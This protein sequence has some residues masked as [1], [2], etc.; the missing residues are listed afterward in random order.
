MSYIK[1]T[2]VLLFCV[3]IFIYVDTPFCRKTSCYIVAVA[4]FR[5]GS[6]LSSALDIHFNGLGCSKFGY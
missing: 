5:V 2:F 4:G 3:H 6:R 1:L